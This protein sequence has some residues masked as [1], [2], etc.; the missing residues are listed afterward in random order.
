MIGIQNHVGNSNPLNG[1]ALLLE[2]FSTFKIGTMIRVTLSALIGLL[3]CVELLGLED[4]NNNMC[5]SDV[6]FCTVASRR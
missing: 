2:V 5:G 6:A 1:C 3:A 4:C